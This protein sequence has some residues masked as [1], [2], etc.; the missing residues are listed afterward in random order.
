MSTT[1]EDQSEAIEACIDA[2]DESI[3]LLSHHPPRALAAALA[4][5]LQAVLAVL[6]AEGESSAE[7]I[8]QWLEEIVRGAC[9]EEP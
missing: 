5:H 7:E 8:R 4:V 1:P 3:A 9:A 6:H 2:L